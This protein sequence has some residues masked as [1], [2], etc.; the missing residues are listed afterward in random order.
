M[1]SFD[2][3]FFLLLT[4]VVSL[5]LG[6]EKP[7][8]R[9]ALEG[10][11]WEFEAETPK[12]TSTAQPNGIYRVYC[13]SNQAQTVQV[14][15]A[16]EYGVTSEV[17]EE[18]GS[19]IPC[20]QNPRAQVRLPFV[21]KDKWKGKVAYVI[22]GLIIT[23]SASSDLDHE[24]IDIE[25][26]GDV[27]IFKVKASGQTRTRNNPNIPL[28]WLYEYDTSANCITTYMFKIGRAHV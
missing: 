22:P 9:A 6:Q 21:L 20:G 13:K 8:A 2:G 4:S 5:A 24:V 1:K 28:A 3:I 11:M 19:L 10:E 26:R 16:E 18:L 12:A 15:G 23:R 27:T 7:Q 14:R 25:E 17:A